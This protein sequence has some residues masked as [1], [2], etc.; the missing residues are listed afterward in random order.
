MKWLE[1]HLISAVVL[2]RYLDLRA[3]AESLVGMPTDTEQ[4]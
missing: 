2:L 4:R 3:A 1:T